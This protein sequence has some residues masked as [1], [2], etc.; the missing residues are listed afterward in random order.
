[1]EDDSQP[2][3]KLDNLSFAKHYRKSC[4]EQNHRQYSGEN[5]SL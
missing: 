2:M 5:D 4:A 3:T 1:M